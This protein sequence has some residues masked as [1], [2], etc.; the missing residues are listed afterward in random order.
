MAL[1]VGDHIAGTPPPIGTLPDGSRAV[2][3]PALPGAELV[4]LPDVGHFI[5]REAPDR[6]R[7]TVTSLLDRV[8]PTRQRRPAETSGV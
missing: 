5:L 7:S 3:S 6:F 1:P 4:I 8:L 2:P